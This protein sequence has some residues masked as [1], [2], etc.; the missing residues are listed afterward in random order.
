MMSFGG[1]ENEYYEPQTED[2]ETILTTKVPQHTVCAAGL[3]VR[4]Q[5]YAVG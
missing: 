1:D 4:A 2:A 3:G 5:S